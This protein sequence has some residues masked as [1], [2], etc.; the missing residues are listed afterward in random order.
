MN[1]ER[2]DVKISKAIGQETFVFL[3]QLGL[4]TDFLKE[5]PHPDRS[6]PVGQSA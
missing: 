3:I 5:V 2:A 6:G 4:F 1:R